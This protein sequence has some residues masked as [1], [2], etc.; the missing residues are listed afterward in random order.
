MPPTPD[1]WVRSRSILRCAGRAS[2]FRFPRQ[3]A[4]W[5]WSP[6]TAAALWRALGF[7]DPLSSS[8]ALRPSQV[9]T[10]GVLGEMGRTELGSETVLRLARVIGRL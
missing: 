3:R 7:P 1:P 8:T 10:L 9:Q 6:S 4:L 5:G 2:R